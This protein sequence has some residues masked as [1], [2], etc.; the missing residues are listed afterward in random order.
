[1]ANVTIDTIDDGHGQS[2]V[3][4]GP[5]RAIGTVET[6]WSLCCPCI[7]YVDDRGMPHHLA[8]DPKSEQVDPKKKTWSCLFTLPV[9]T[10]WTFLLCVRA[11]KLGDGSRD[12]AERAFT[13]PAVR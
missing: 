4:G 3:A 6:D 9:F 8:P 7:I 1:V 10:G 2:P 11:H 5:C 13:T 12:H